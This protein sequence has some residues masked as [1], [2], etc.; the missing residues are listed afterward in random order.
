MGS[1]IGERTRREVEEAD[2]PVV[3]VPYWRLFAVVGGGGFSPLF[4]FAAV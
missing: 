1:R 4:Y 2:L 3:R